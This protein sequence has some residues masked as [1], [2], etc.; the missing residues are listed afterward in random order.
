[1]E[2]RTDLLA[3]EPQQERRAETSPASRTTPAVSV[4]LPAYNAGEHLYPA[5]RSVLDD[6]FAD[7]EVLVVDDGS[8][9]GSVDGLIAAVADDRL[10]VLR[11]RNHGLAHALNRGMAEARSG[12]IA[13]M[14][15]DDLVVPGR[16]AA[17][18]QH[19]IAHP[20]VVLVGG[21]VDRMVD[22]VAR[23]TTRFPLTHR[24]IVEGL[25]AGRHVLCHPAIMLRASAVRAVG[26]YWQH[27]VS[28]DWDLFL[29][30]SA[31]GALA[32]LD[33]VV[34]RYRFHDGGINAGSMAQV[35]R[36]IRLAVVN[37]RRRAAG[38]EAL[39]PESLRRS[40]GPIGRLSLAGQTRSLVLYRQALQ[41]AAGGRSVRSRVELGAAAVL[42]PRQALHRLR[43]RC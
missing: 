37:H 15:A 35:R 43:H 28:E 23:S 16:F 8:T 13:R 36:N 20:E 29:R 19:L 39:T 9:D 4:V 38:R 3:A 41:S 2:P 21:Q 11:Q 26:G 27:G 31:L 25:L 1:M 6:G 22:G 24:Q 30:L 34:L 10:I 12:F 33:S 40:T 42:W 14:D 5:V 32:N 18:H 17:Q 7:L